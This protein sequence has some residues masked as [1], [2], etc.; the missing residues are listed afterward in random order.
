M[1]YQIE[2]NLFLIS[3]C[4]F[5]LFLLS[6]GLGKIRENKKNILTYL[7]YPIV[8]FFVVVSFRFYLLPDYYSGEKTWLFLILSLCFIIALVIYVILQVNSIKSSN[9]KISNYN[10]LKL[11]V[12]VTTLSF[13]ILL[14]AYNSIPD[15]TISLTEVNLALLQD[16]NEKQI[17]LG[18]SLI[19]EKNKKIVAN[20]DFETQKFVNKIDS[21]KFYALSKHDKDFYQKNKYTQLNFSPNKRENL[22]PISFKRV[23]IFHA[24]SIVELPELNYSFELISNYRKKM[25]HILFPKVTNSGNFY[26]EIDFSKDSKILMTDILRISRGYNL[27]KDE[28]KLLSLILMNDSHKSYIDYYGGSYNYGSYYFQN[29]PIVSAIAMLTKL[30]NEILSTRYLIISHI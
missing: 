16:E 9:F 8:M 12:L 13:Y 28:E 20:L 3:I 6:N 24:S 15:W 1:K 14:K 18:N 17:F 2:F 29:L 30:Q 4:F 26:D 7:I 25:L 21:L 11:V 19:T 22:I 10:F 27:T 5:S 23:D